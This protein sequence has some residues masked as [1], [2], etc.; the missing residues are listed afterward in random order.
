MPRSSDLKPRMRALAARSALTRGSV[1]GRLAAG[2]W[3]WH[4]TAD[5]AIL[6]HG[7]EAATGLRSAD[8]RRLTPDFGRRQF[9]AALA[10][11][12]RVAASVA[13]EP[14]RPAPIGGQL[15]TGPALPAR[16]FHRTP[17]APS[18]TRAPSGEVAADH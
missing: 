10:G 15:Y 1:C 9:L 4:G 12:T 14:P 18:A 5:T 2:A 7:H 8:M 17:A 13:P 3:P 11:L 6:V 16:G